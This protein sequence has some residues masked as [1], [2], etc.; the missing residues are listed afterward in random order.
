[1]YECFACMYT[2]YMTGTWGNQ[3]KASDPL[4][5]ESQVVVTHRVHAGNCI[6][7]FFLKEKQVF[8]TTE[9]SLQ[10]WAFLFDLCLALV[11]EWCCLCKKN[12]EML[13]YF[14]E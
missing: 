10:P 5:L 6:W 12:L 9:P 3:K 11:S 2:L 4:E 14:E 7:I 8:S 1:M 13:L